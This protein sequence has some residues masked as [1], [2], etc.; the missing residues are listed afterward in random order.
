MFIKLLNENHEPLITWHLI[1]V[2]PTKWSVS[3]FNSSNNAV[4][5]ESLQLYYQYFTIVKP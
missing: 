2:Y 3:D 5:V 4:V 1:N